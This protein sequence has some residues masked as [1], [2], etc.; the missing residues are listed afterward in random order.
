[1]PPR[2]LTTF[3]QSLADF[4]VKVGT[5]RGWEYA[6]FL[7]NCNGPLLSLVTE[8][9]PARAEPTP[10]VVDWANAGNDII[11]HHNHLSQESL[12]MA[13][14]NGVVIYFDEIFAH[15]ADG[16]TYWGRAL[17]S[18]AVLR[19]IGDRDEHLTKAENLFRDHILS[20]DMHNLW[21]AVGTL[22]TKEVIN[23]A[24][25]IRQYVDYGFQ[26]G[27]GKLPSLKAS[28]G[29]GKGSVASY[30]PSMDIHIDAVAKAFALTI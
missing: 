17:N 1:M 23:R 24:M 22:F 8:R 6:A 9:L 13:D 28:L 14:W 18:D 25:R 2:T 5:E 20:K 10:T 15:C 30:G 16:T 12:S 27:G 3:E 4:V 21:P 29:L 7:E 11:V 26:W 19:M